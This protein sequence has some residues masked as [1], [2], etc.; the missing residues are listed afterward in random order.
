MA[1]CKRD[2]FLPLDGHEDKKKNDDFGDKKKHVNYAKYRARKLRD[3]ILEYGIP[4]R[5]IK[6]DSK[7]S[8]EPL[9]SNKTKEGRYQNRRVEITIIQR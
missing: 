3:V 4:K 1:F 2:L 7:G 8:S 9:G 5:K 6:T